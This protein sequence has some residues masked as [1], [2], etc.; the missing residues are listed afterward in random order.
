MD[1]RLRSTYNEDAIVE[2]QHA[3]IEEIDEFLQE[4]EA[5]Y[6]MV[7]RSLEKRESDEFILDHE[8]DKNDSG[9]ISLK[10]DLTIKV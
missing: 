5:Q 10:G 6:D 7:L 2:S 9:V 1:A 4:W 3:R 8:G